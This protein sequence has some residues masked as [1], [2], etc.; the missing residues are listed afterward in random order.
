MSSSPFEKRE[1]LLAEFAREVRQFNGL[2][3]SFFRAAA[4][5]VGLN[6]TD[7]Q[8][9]DLLDMTGPTTAGQLAELTGLTTGAI[10]G[11]IDRLE[12]AGLV[13][14]ERDPADGRRVI[15]RLASNEEALR[16]MSPV[17]DS[18]GG[19]WDEL[20]A[21]YSD[22]QVA[23]LVEFL[24]RSN[25]MSREEISRLREAPEGAGSD[26]SAP[27]GD[28]ERGRLVVSA[29]TSTLMVRAAAGMSDLYRANFTGSMPSVKVEA[30]TI[31]IRY[32][33]R[34]WLP[35][36]RQR[37]AEI[38]LNAAIPWQIV[39]WSGGSEVA[40]ELGGLDL[41]ELDANGAGSMFLIELS[42]PARVVPIRLGGSGSQFTV[43]RPPGVAAR[44]HLQ[45]WGS[46]VVLDGQT[47]YS[48]DARLQ[49]PD[50]EGAARGYDLEV[51][52]SGSMVTVAAS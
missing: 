50:Y 21:Q 18:I 49:T 7:L 39:I 52:G 31:T 25:A 15:V 45:G 5:Q 12:K 9:T 42:E 35:A 41:L 24:K 43:R 13:R 4:A 1:E 6:V 34:L 17:F 36:R 3:A 32:P 23:F 33:Q 44:V 26:L 22:E 27:L 20:A 37:K 38:E 11:M 30:G 48:S 28:L 51:S 40:A 29:G 8:V 16:K 2:S 46:G 10:T 47:G 19:S 14:R